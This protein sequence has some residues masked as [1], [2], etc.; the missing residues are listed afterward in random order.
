LRTP[1]IG[2]AATGH[3]KD[4]TQFLCGRPIE[5][6]PYGRNDSVGNIKAQVASALIAD[7]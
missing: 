1:P 3:M 4:T 2:F 7:D 6:I 5:Q